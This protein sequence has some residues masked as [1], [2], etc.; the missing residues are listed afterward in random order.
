[1]GKRR[2]SVALIDSDSDD[3][4]NSGDDI[5]AVIANVVFYLH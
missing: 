4:S 5:E 3:D 2:R 1:M